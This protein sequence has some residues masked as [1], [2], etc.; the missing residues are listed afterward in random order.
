[1]ARRAPSPCAWDYSLLLSSFLLSTLFLFSPLLS[2]LS[3]HAM[4]IASSLQWPDN[5]I[6]KLIRHSFNAD[7]IKFMIEKGAPTSPGV[8]FLLLLPLL[9]SISYP[10]FSYC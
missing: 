2:F 6:A 8:F 10:P 1:M 5:V 7:L 3:A 4:F 9:T